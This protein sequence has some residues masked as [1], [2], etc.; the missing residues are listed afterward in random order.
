MRQSRMVCGFKT[1]FE[2]PIFKCQWGRQYMSPR[3]LG[4]HRK[5]TGTTQSALRRRCEVCLAGLSP[6]PSP[7]LTRVLRLRSAHGAQG[8]CSPSA[9]AQ[10]RIPSQTVLGPLFI[11]GGV[12]PIEIRTCLSQPQTTQADP[13]MQ[14]GRTLFRPPPFWPSPSARMRGL[15]AGPVLR[16]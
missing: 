1:H 4:P 9:S 14:L 7:S 2:T 12:R 8:S 6:C 5:H 15:T 16:V 13:G 10:P 3:T 11:S